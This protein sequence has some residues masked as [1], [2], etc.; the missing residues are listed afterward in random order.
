MAV[1]RLQHGNDWTPPVSRIPLEL[2]AL[3]FAH[4][5]SKWLVLTVPNVCHTWRNVCREMLAAR[6][7]FGWS[8]VGKYWRDKA[9]AL[10]DQALIWVAPKF[11][12][13]T[14]ANIDFCRTVTDADAAA[15]NRTYPDFPG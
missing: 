11:P 9:S 5:E 1:V 14:S 2:L 6:L 15:L 12:K 7:D 8:V 3:V 10:S 4:V 13:A